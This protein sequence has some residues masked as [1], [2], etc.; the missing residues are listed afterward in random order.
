MCDYN[1]RNL[2]NILAKNRCI[3]IFKKKCVLGAI[4]LVLSPCFLERESRNIN[5][6]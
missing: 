2:I 4:R 5:K 6:F 3:L 1:T